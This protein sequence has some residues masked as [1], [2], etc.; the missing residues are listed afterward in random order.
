MEETTKKYVC[1][2]CMIDVLQTDI[3]RLFYLKGNKRPEKGTF[4]L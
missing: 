4:V 3:Q 1:P 2:L